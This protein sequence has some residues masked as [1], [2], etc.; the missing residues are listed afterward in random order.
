LNQA[1]VPGDAAALPGP[2][3]GP[4]EENETEVAYG[5]NTDR[6]ESYAAAGNSYN[7]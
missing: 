2:V 4:A 6:R 5:V 3:T 7:Q 1:N